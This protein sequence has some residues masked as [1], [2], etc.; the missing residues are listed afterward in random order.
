MNENL[1]K[2]LTF[3]AASLMILA[4][5]VFMFA[6]AEEDAGGTEG[7]EMGAGAGG[8]GQFAWNDLHA[9][10]IWEN[11]VKVEKMFNVTICETVKFDKDT[12]D[13]YAADHIFGELFNI[14]WDDDPEPRITIS[15]QDFEDEKQDENNLTVY[16][17]GDYYDGSQPNEEDK[18]R[19]AY[20]TVNITKPNNPPTPVAWVAEEGNWT[21][22]DLS[23]ENDVTFIVEEGDEITLRFDGSHSWDPDGENVTD[24][25]WDLNEDGFFGGAGETGENKSRILTAGKSYYY[26]LQVGDERGKFSDVTLDFTIR[27]RSPE[28]KADLTVGEIHYENKNKAKDNYEVGDVIIVQPKIINEGE[29]DTTEN[30]FTVLIEYAKIEANDDEVYQPL[31]QIVITD[32]IPPGQSKIPT[33]NWD[34]GGLAEGQYKL[35]VTADSDEEVDEEY[36]DNND[37]KTNRITL[38]ERIGAGTPAI[39]IEFVTADRTKAYINEPIN[40][41]VCIKNEGNGDANYVD[42]YYDIGGEDQY[43]RTLDVVTAGEN[44]S[45]VFQFTGDAKGDYILGFVAKDDGSQVGDKV[46]VTVTVEKKDDGGT[47]LPPTPDDDSE[48]SGFIPGFELLT[49]VGAAVAGAVLFSSRRRR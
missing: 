41:T 32:A 3:L 29:N 27:V 18:D 6:Q 47:V 38:E 4:L 15:N 34:T 37:N 39:S 11:N 24:W 7:T 9:F 19:W 48:S 5:P 1:S 35:R 44:A 13:A 23:K 45:I 20:K 33:Y 8:S 40:V 17:L 14:T 26:G 25:K 28:E 46:T 30:G 31:T 21:W 22:V 2:M 12:G 10:V 42:I 16:V 43:Y 49:M 36:E